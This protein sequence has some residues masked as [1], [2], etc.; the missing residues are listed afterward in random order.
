MIIESLF[1]NL[2]RC[3]IFGLLIACKLQINENVLLM[4]NLVCLY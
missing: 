3:N 4:L 1:S 2:P